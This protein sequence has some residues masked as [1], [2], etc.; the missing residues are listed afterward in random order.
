MKNLTDFNSKIEFVLTDIDD[1][2]TTEGQL[3]AKAYDSL[4]KL[5][6]AGLKV[7]PITGRPAGWCEMIARF[8]PVEGIVG[9]NGGFYFRYA[10][11]SGDQ[12]DKTD[13]IKKMQRWFFSEDKTIKQNKI[14]LDAIAQEILSEV[15]G[16]AL[17]S[18]QF[19]RLMD[20]AV[21]FCED[22][23]PLHQSDVQRIVNIFEKHGAQAKVSSIHVNGWFGNYNKLTTTFQFLKNEFNLSE[24]EALKKC[25]FV[26]D[27]PNDE[28]MFAKFPHSF[29][30]ANIKNFVSQMKT[31]P[32]YVSNSVGGEGFSEIAERI[33][34]NGKPLF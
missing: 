17:A 4:W 22:V 14:K 21:D 34:A 15:Q 8:W 19:C 25:I 3:H 1:T 7:I 20:L 28:P 18:D 32:T 30:V 23:P 9:E 29:G 6:H 10:A 33:L 16:S 2:L 5:Q 11:K 12:Y 13:K 24:D 27:S 31:L 26:G